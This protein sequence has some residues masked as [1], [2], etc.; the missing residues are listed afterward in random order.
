MTKHMTKIAIIGAGPGGLALAVALRQYG[1]T[2]I[3]FERAHDLSPSGSAITLFPNGLRAL[4]ACAAGLAAQV[5]AAGQP[6]HSVTLRS[7]LGQT[8]FE[9]PVTMQAR[10]GYPMLNIRWATLRAV[11]AAHLPAGS[12]RFG[13]ACEQL[14]QT[15]QGVTLHFVN[16][17]TAMADFV[18]AADGIGSQLRQQFHS[19]CKPRYSGRFSWR[20]IVQMPRGECR[21]HRSVITTSDT[22][23]TF[24]TADMGDGFVYWSAGMLLP[25]PAS[26]PEATQAEL[27]KQHLLAA[28][29][30]WGEPV[31][32]LIGATSADEIIVR[33]I[34]DCAPL[35]TWRNGRM[36]LMGDAAHPMAPSLG[37]GAN[38]AFEDACELANV[39]AADGNQDDHLAVYE[40]RRIPRTSIIQVRSAAQGARAYETNHE[41]HL[42]ESADKMWRNQHEFE[43]WLY[44]F[45]PSNALKQAVQSFIEAV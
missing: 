12:I 41:Q 24:M 25:N 10:Y 31:L 35:P 38:T 7:N 9:S 1:I 19:A 32:G 16:G 40:A 21:A 11:L 23:K 44:Q 27:A 17:E 5:I 18:V 20:G 42:R 2:P 15:E 8:F 33:A 22:G 6:V 26:A 36:M 37:Q 30:D 45:Q 4:D 28:F 3:V 43:D 39:L 29:A 13:M 34:C 14:H